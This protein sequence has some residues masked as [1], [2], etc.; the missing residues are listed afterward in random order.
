MNVVGPIQTKV[1]LTNGPLWYRRSREDPVDVD[2]S[3]KNSSEDDSFRIREYIYKVSLSR[4]DVQ[5]SEN[6]T[7][8]KV[9]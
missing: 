3:V 2:Y 4:Q 6:D 7:T 9:L 5:S 8:R 1:K